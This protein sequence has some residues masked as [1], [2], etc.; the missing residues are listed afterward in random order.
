MVVRE[1][2]L[3]DHEILALRREYESKGLGDLVKQGHHLVGLPSLH[4][5][6]YSLISQPTFDKALDAHKPEGR[7]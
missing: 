7:P 5:K 4:A 6:L 2:N 3:E 1:M